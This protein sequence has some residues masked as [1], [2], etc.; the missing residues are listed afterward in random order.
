MELMNNRMNPEE[1]HSFGDWLRQRRK[2]LDWSQAALA[3]R[4]GCTAA[5]IRKIEASER[6]P[7]VQLADLLAA[8]L[9]VPEADRST[10]RQVARQLRS[11]SLLPSAGPLPVPAAPITVTTRHNL[12]APMT[13]LINRLR[14]TANVA[15]LLQQVDL[16]LLTLL[17]PPGIGKTRLAIHTAEQVAPHFRDGVWF[18]DLAP[19]TDAALV[20]PTIA[21]ALAV[22][23]A[24]STS[25]LERLCALLMDKRLLLVLDNCEQVS[26]AASEVGALLRGCK[27]LKVLATSRIPLL[28]A[29]EHEYALPPLSLP[30]LSLRTREMTPAIQPEQL[31]NYEAVQ[32]FVARVRQHQHDFV[33]T[34]TNGEAIAAIC[35]RLDGLPLA[36]E[37]AAAALRRMDLR[38]LVTLLHNEMSWLHELQSPA[39]DLPAR[40]RTLY[41]AIGWSYRLLDATQQ[42]T[43]R[44]L[45]CFVGSFTAAAAQALC[46]ADQATLDHLTDH[47]LL[48]RAPGRWQMLEMMREFAL[49]QM[50]SA[51]RALVQQRHTAYFVTQAAQQPA[52][53]MELFAQDHDNFRAALVAAVAD[54]DAYAAFTLCIKLVWFWE[55]RGYLR[56]EVGLVR[57]ALAMP[58]DTPLRFDLVE[59]MSTLAWQVHQFDVA[60]EFADKLHVL[61]RK[62][63]DPLEVA[64]VLNLW[65]RILIEQGELDR[66]QA[67]LQENERIAR[68]IPH[69]FNPGCPLA[70]LGEI[71]LVSGQWQRAEQQLQAALTLLLRTE[72]NLYTDIFIAMVHT[73]L[74]ELALVRADPS[75]AFHELQQVLPYA[76]LYL[77]RLHCLLVTLI[78]FLLMPLPTPSTANVQAAATLLGAIAGLS[79]RTGDTLSPFHQQLIDKRSA[80]A[81]QWLTRHEW[82]AAWQVGHAWTPAQAANA[83]DEWLAFSEEK[84]R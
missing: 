49:A 76:R 56:E 81:Q 26:E 80:I 5:T 69:L 39:R 68:Q 25:L 9:G 51:E 15:G 73:D 1:S 10:F 36:L 27:G 79:E 8:A 24:G 20:L 13:S 62:H 16:R 28:L 2:A 67:T 19:L 4:V 61:A 45:G 66:A 3:E 77:R 84:T 35:L 57:A 63:G 52:V 17:G 78:G 32:L 29:G 43:F 74:A 14:D 34:A 22:A 64:R 46:D 71:A 23:E 42:A 12:P 75:L 82:Q 18:V 37:L 41:Q 54:L 31:M 53:S 70:Q 58:V 7:S 65:G 50:E 72:G 11:V 59:R 83:T 48:A 33:V 60:T 21:H 6:K 30:P 55:L 47:N 38:Q 40:Q 44:Q